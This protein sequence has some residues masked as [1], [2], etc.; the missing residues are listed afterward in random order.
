M[1]DASVTLQTLTL[2]DPDAKTGQYEVSYTDSTIEMMILQKGASVTLA[3]VGYYSR[4]PY[5][6]YT[7]TAVLEG[8]KI[9][10]ANGFTYKVMSCIEYFW[11]NSFICYECHLE[12]VPAYIH[13]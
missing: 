12:K 8:D 10:D 2:G 11:L 3:G 7:L 9:L 4:Y 13:V 5:T 1:S 6:G